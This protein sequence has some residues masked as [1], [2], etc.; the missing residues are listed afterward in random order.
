[1][2]RNK[3]KSNVPSTGRME[4][5]MWRT[6]QVAVTFAD[7]KKKRNKYAARKNKGRREDY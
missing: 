4:R 5:R 6:E 1:M 3:R 7:R 2:S